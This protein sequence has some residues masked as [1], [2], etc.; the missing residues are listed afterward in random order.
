ML[1]VLNVA[2]VGGFTPVVYRVASGNQV[3][4]CWPRSEAP[5]PV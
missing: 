2:L 3:H 5:T 1:S 4:L